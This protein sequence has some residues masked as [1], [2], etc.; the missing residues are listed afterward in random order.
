[1]KGGIRNLHSQAALVMAIQLA[2]KDDARLCPPMPSPSSSSKS[3]THPILDSAHEDTKDAPTPFL[4]SLF[5]SSA[6][7]SLFGLHADRE[8]RRSARRSR[9]SRQTSARD[10]HSKSFF[11]FFALIYIVDGWNSGTRYGSRLQ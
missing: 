4:Q 11:F 2:S 9:P 8:N 1:M 6:F 10:D 3:A 5:S 7:L